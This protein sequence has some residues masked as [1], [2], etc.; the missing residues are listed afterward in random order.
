ME[1]WGVDHCV[2]GRQGRK[3]IRLE[4]QGM[5]KEEVG[6]GRRAR[7]SERAGAVGHLERQE[8]S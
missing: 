4:S 7:E 6:G 3:G 2:R 1:E 8:G 5:T